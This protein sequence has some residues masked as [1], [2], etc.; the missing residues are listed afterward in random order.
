MVKNNKPLIF[1]NFGA[2]LK[3]NVAPN[4]NKQAFGL[5]GN[6]WEA[7]N[8]GRY[9]S[10]YYTPY[11]DSELA[12]NQYNR[13]TVQGYAREMAYQQPW[14]M[15]AI[16][17]L[18][19]FAVSDKY[20]PHYKGNDTKWGVEATDWLKQIFY[21]N[22]CTRGKNYDFKTVIHLI[23]QLIDIDGDILLVLGRDKYNSPKLQLIPSHRVRSDTGNIY[24]DPQ[25]QYQPGPYE[26]TVTS[27]GVVYTKKGE[28][29][30]YNIINTDNMV[31][32]TFNNSNKSTFV[33]ARDSMLCYD[34]QLADK[35]RGLPT[36]ASGI[37]QAL[38]VSEVEASLLE[39]VKIRS[40]YAVV[41]KTPEG[42][43]PYEEEQA[44]RNAA[45]NVN[46]LLGFSAGAGGADA[47]QGL[48]IVQKPNIKYVSCAGGDIVFPSV[49]TT[50]KETSDFITRLEKG[51]LA[52][53]GVPHALLFSPDDV[54]GKM[55]SGVSNIFNGS[56]VKRQQILDTYANYICSW[57]LATAIAN[58]DLPPNNEE[59]LTNTF[60][61]SHP[62][63]FSVDDVKLRQA[64]LNDLAAGVLT[65]SDLARKNNTTVEALIL[66]KEKEAVLKLNAAKRVSIATG[67]TM[68]LALKQLDS[69]TEFTP[70]PAPVNK[71]IE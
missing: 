39:L 33:S 53:L 7:P 45:T 21:P 69:T 11:Q 48:R 14:I 18:S 54:S 13:S 43:G 44:Y 59:I 58:G 63:P 66:Q 24:G 9:R 37:L 70:T 28:P 42:E 15:S 36:I 5:V 4:N 40:M 12:I 31:T 68:D 61:F 29:I 27:D 22:C 6:I 51:V 52:T 30:G 32:G 20:S 47:S 19:L 49:S 26:D 3:L 10:R 34:V 67:V 50:D 64:D 8:A 55:N 62:E 2:P 65:L 1:D 71:P 38:S 17:T 25:Q 23:S 57:A 46:T 41:E 60:E 16:K 56:I 35:G